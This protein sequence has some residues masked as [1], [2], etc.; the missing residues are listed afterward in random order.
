MQYNT[1]C[2]C[3]RK[4]Y[5][6]RTLHTRRTNFTYIPGI[7]SFLALFFFCNLLRFGGAFFFAIGFAFDLED[8][9]SSSVSSDAEDPPK[10]SASLSSAI[11]FVF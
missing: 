9:I 7:G 3:N 1:Q 10:R 8:A 2:V 6:T 4:S 11:I 5:T